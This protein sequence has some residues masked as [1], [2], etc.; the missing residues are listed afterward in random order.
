MEVCAFL[1]HPAS[2][3]PRTHTHNPVFGRMRA[4]HFAGASCWSWCTL[5][6]L[7]ARPGL[8]VLATDFGLLWRMAKSR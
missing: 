8:L 1:N 5:G 2:S 3:Q 4:T 6:V 7:M